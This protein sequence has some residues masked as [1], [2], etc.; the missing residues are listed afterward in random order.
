MLRMRP[1]IPSVA[2]RLEP[3]HRFGCSTSTGFLEYRSGVLLLSCFF[4]AGRGQTGRSPVHRPRIGRR[5]LST[6]INTTK[7]M[8]HVAIPP[9]L[10]TMPL[11]TNCATIRSRT[12][13]LNYTHCQTSLR[14][15]DHLSLLTCLQK[16]V[17]DLFRVAF[18]GLLSS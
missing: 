5:R 8:A 16:P 11:H 3:E 18:I 17:H 15:L 9:P 13:L 12:Y 7:P 2:S 4:R 1:L 10:Q 14:Y 6:L